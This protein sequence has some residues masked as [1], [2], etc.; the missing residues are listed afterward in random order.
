MRKRVVTRVLIYLFIFL[1]VP[2]VLLGFWITQPVWGRGARSSRSVP[3]LPTRARSSRCRCSQ[4]RAPLLDPT[5]PGGSHIAPS[6]FATSRQ[7]PMNPAGSGSHPG[8][9]VPAFA[10]ACSTVLTE[11]GIEVGHEA[12][13]EEYVREGEDHGL[14]P[15]MLA[16]DEIRSEVANVLLERAIRRKAIDIVAEAATRKPVPLSE[17]LAEDEE[18]DAA[19]EEAGEEDRQDV[20]E[21]EPEGSEAPTEEQ[22]NE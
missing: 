8:S 16:S 22:E 10:L 18:T 13:R 9:Q 1:V 6:A 4:A 15:E 19:G 3:A 12:V 5:G 7:S 20:Q 17:F 21:D 14:D 2:V 11:K